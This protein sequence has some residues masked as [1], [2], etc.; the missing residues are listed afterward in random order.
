MVRI[1]GGELRAGDDAAEI[2][3]FS[4]LELG[5]LKVTTD[6]LAYLERYGV[7]DPASGREDRL[8][9]KPSIQP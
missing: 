1:I 4:T 2:G 6:L 3:W 7:Y 8:S 9:V 5:E